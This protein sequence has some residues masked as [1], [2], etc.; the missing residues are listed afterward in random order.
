V[1]LEELPELEKLFEFNIYVYRLVEVYDEDK[2]KTEIVTQLM[3]RSHRSYANTMYLNLYGSHFSYIKNLKMYSKSYCCC[4]C[5][6][7]WKTGV[8]PGAAYKIPQT[9]FD[10]L[11]DEGI[12]I[13]EDLK[14]LDLKAIKK[15]L[16]ASA[17]SGPKGLLYG[18]VSRLMI[19][20]DGP[21]FTLE[22]H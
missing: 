6:K 22:S 20:W 18:L 19:G 3:Q 8:F 9:I 21:L 12:D 11:E 16:G 2:D 13:P 4:K 17:K 10:L 15:A 14:Y 1:T 7:M 5:D